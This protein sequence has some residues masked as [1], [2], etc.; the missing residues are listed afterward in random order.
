MREIKFRAFYKKDKT[1]QYW[2]GFE[3]L[4]LMFNIHNYKIEDYEIMEWTGLKDKNGKPIYEGDILEM[5]TGD[6]ES[7]RFEVVWSDEF[8]AFVDKGSLNGTED[9]EFNKCEIVGNIWES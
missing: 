8:A 5:W 4:A 1:M 9:C 2:G 3:E 6:Q 7:I